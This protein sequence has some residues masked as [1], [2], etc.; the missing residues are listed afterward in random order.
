MQYRIEGNPFPVV[1]CE[2][3]A[4]ET[5]KCQKSTDYKEPINKYS[6][7]THES[8]TISCD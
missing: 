1:V 2:L 3:Q 4:G 6:A 8:L 5:V 7:I